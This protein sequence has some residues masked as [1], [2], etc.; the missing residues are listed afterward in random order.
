[1][2]SSHDVILAYVYVSVC[3]CNVCI[4]LGVNSFLFQCKEDHD[5]C[6]DLTSL[7]Q[8][9]AGWGC[10]ICRNLFATPPRGGIAQG[11]FEH[12]SAFPYIFVFKVKTEDIVHSLVAIDALLSAGTASRKATCPS[13]TQNGNKNSDEMWE[14]GGALCYSQLKY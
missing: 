10:Y 4:Y 12:L 5:C 8:S 11:V 1:M 7:D 14:Q 9:H 6:H 2:H 3:S 13:Q